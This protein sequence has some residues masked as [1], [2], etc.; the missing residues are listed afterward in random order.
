[1]RWDTVR[2]AVSKSCL[3]RFESRIPP[4]E[5]VCDRIAITS[6]RFSTIEGVICLVN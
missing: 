4:A 2:R 1:M 6:G 5:L 3:K